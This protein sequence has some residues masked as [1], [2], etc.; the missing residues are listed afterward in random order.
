MPYVAIF[1][2]VATTIA[3]VALL[4]GGEVDKPGRIAWAVTLSVPAALAIASLERRPVLLVPAAFTSIGMSWTLFTGIPL[5]LLPG[6]AYAVAYARATD[7]DTSSTRATIAICVPIALTAAAAVLLFVGPHRQDCATTAHGET[8]GTL[9][10]GG[11]NARIALVIGLAV[12]AVVSGM[13]A[14]DPE[15]A[16]DR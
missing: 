1:G 4:A 13:V 7:G 10:A 15:P 14:A 11:S 2:A 9:V 5:L 16:R 3:D 8:C 6:I 12:L